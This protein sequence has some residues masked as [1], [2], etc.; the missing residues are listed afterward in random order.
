M[1]NSE[2]DYSRLVE[3]F[4]KMK[5]IINYYFCPL[6][7]NYQYHLAPAKKVPEEYFT[8]D[9]REHLLANSKD[10]CITIQKNI[11]PDIAQYMYSQY[12]SQN[13]Y[14]MV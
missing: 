7:Y 10:G 3:F 12:Q 6:Q 1:Q 8:K 2:D 5:P 9:F 11:T 14:V 4:Q 13:F